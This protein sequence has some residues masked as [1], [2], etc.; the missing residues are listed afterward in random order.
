MRG[1]C[2]LVLAEVVYNV[3]LVET[4]S[5]GGETCATT[6]DTRVEYNMHLDLVCERA[7]QRQSPDKADI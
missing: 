6:T 2:Q 1:V 7:K 5:H 3:M 4:H